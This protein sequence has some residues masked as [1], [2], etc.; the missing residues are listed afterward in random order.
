MEDELRES[1]AVR[2]GSYYYVPED[3]KAAAIEEQEKIRRISGSAVPGLGGSGIRRFGGSKVFDSWFLA[4]R[5]WLGLSL[6]T[7]CPGPWF[8]ARG[9][10]IVEAYLLL[11]AARLAQ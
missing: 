3:Q 11:A 2:E 1:P 9:S 7:P 6:P 8:S 10:A 5:I 4:V